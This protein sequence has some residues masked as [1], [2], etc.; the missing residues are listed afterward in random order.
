MSKWISG[1]PVTR[2]RAISLRDSKL[3]F[4]ADT[5]TYNGTLTTETLTA[6]RTWTLPNETG[7][8]LTRASAGLANGSLLITTDDSV[9]ATAI[10]LIFG[11]TEIYINTVEKNTGNTD[12][13]I[14]ISGVLATDLMLVGMLGTSQLAGGTLILGPTAIPSA[15]RSEMWH[16]HLANISA[17]SINPAA[18]TTVS[19]LVIS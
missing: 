3:F 14:S 13:T 2:F 11:T 16:V 7:E 4:A 8:L 12:S 10:D 1:Q 15:T 19:Y 18:T 17:E 6:A 9:Y 5:S